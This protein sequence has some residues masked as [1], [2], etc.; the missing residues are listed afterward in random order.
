MVQRGRY[1]RDDT[2]T[3]VIC[4]SSCVFRVSFRAIFSAGFAGFLLNR[5][6]WALSSSVAWCFKRGPSPLMAH[7]EA[8]GPCPP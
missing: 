1:G 4:V 8:S 6:A 5:E 7:L 3:R 2:L